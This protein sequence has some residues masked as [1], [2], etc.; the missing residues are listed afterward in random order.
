MSAAGNAPLSGGPL[1]LPP[2]SLDVEALDLGAEATAVGLEL[3]GTESREPV[4]G[5]EAAAIWAAVFPALAA[6]EVFAIDFF[7]HVDRVRDF[8][9]MNEIHFREAA[10]R[11]LVLRQ[12][13]EVQLEQLFARFEGETFGVRAGV[14]AEAPDATLEKELSRR[15]LDAYQPAYTRY[16]FCAVCEPEDG[17]VTLLSNTLWPTEVIRRLRPAV[18]RFDVYIS[19]PH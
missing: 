13:T 17:W 3:L 4:K 15:G 11:C 5:K 9:N 10:E 1:E 18:Q 7:S 19:R 2:F 14:A 12:P 8:C 6:D 16:T